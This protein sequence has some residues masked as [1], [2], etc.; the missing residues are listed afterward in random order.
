MSRYVCAAGTLPSPALISPGETPAT[1]ASCSTVVP[2]GRSAT[3][4]SAPAEQGQIAQA[5]AIVTPMADRTFAKFGFFKVDPAW[6]RLDAEQR[7]SDK[8]EFLAACED[9][10]LDR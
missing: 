4:V 3:V 1:R 8:Q 9:F 2:R 7:A 5:V 6:R 10:A